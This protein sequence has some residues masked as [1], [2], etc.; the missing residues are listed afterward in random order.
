MKKR[1]M[2]VLFYL[3]VC[4]CVL[5]MSC[6]K[7]EDNAIKLTVHTSAYEVVKN[8]KDAEGNLL[9]T[10]KLTDGLLLRISYLVLKQN[11]EEVS[12]VA[13]D[14]RYISNVKDIASYTTGELEPGVYRVVV[15]SD[16]VKG[17]EE[18]NWLIF[19]AQNKGFSVTCVENVGVYNTFGVAYMDSVVVDSKKMITLNTSRRGSLL[20]LLLK[21]TDKMTEDW[22]SFGRKE[23]FIYAISGRLDEDIDYPDES[24]RCKWGLGTVSLQRYFPSVEREILD[25]YWQGNT[26]SLLLKN[27]TDAR[28]ELDFASGEMTLIP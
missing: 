23:H 20:T 14:T 2:K 24:G 19:D 21:N 13:N 15:L 26:F 18:F 10:G 16:F 6:K 12:V 11:E 4:V 8:L 22:Y 5:L 25:V 9:F 17:H 27:G 1:E 3:F 7:E 28:V